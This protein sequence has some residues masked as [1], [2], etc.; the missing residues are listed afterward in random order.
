MNH[1]VRRAAWVIVPLPIIAIPLYSTIIHP[2]INPYKNSE[3]YFAREV[4]KVTGLNAQIFCTSGDA[5][6]LAWVGQQYKRIHIINSENFHLSIRSLRS[7]E[8]NSYF[9]V[10][11]HDLKSLLKDAEPF[12]KK[13]IL[14]RNVHNKKK[15]LFLLGV[16]DA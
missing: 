3:M 13:V 4:Y 9:V 14:Q 8:T 1:I 6:V 12:L 11:E 5:E 16:K 10:S 15:M 7:A 2:L